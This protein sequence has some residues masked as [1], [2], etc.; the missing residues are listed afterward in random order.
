MSAT[1]AFITVPEMD[2]ALARII[3]YWNAKKTHTDYFSV[4]YEDVR[5]WTIMGLGAEYLEIRLGAHQRSFEVEMLLP[6]PVTI[7][8]YVRPKSTVCESVH[9]ALK[10]VYARADRMGR[11]EET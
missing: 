5:R 9:N 10:C 6:T 2:L 8:C 11:G 1:A 7:K 3:L 4:E